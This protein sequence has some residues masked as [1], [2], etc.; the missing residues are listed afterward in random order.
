M[1][2][3]ARLL[4][5]RHRCIAPDWPG[6]GAARGPDTSLTPEV[7]L[8]F[9]RRF[10]AQVVRHPALV[11]AAGHSAAYVMTVAREMPDAF[12]HIVLVAPT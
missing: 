8:G 11:V 2:R 3:L 6:F 1:H 4:E 12:S 10:V 7:L 9:L 5:V